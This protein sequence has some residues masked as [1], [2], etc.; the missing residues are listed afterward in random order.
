MNKEINNMINVGYGEQNCPVDAVINNFR[1][2]AHQISNYPR[3]VEFSRECIDFFRNMADIIEES[4][5]NICFKWYEDVIKDLPPLI[6][7]IR[8]YNGKYYMQ[9]IKELGAEPTLIK[10]KQRK[11]KN[12]NGKIIVK[13]E[14]EQERGE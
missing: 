5:A 4:D 6:V 7:K 3:N 12:K 14:S 13:K 9:Y 1:K 8:K 11:G 10:S 2:R